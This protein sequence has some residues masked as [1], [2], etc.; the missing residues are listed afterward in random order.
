MYLPPPLDNRKRSAP[1]AIL[2]AGSS[3]PIHLYRRKVSFPLSAACFFLLP[4]E[5]A[6]FVFRVKQCICHR[7]GQPQTFRAS[8]FPGR[9]QVASD[10]LASIQG[11]LSLCIFIFL[12]RILFSGK[13]THRPPPRVAAGVSRLPLP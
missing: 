7:R 1:P 10:P 13:T 4:A 5:T 11:A 12:L 3:C 8:R 6:I 2:T 9:R